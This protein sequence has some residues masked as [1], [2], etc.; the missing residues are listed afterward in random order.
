[1][2]L[3]NIT[4]QIFIIFSLDIIQSL[5]QRS[6]FRIDSIIFRLN[7]LQTNTRQSGNTFANH[8]NLFEPIILLSNSTKSINKL[9]LSSISLP[10]LHL[11]ISKP[12]ILLL[13]LVLKLLSKFLKLPLHILVLFLQADIVPPRLL[14]FM[15]QY[16]FILVDCV[17]LQP[18]LPHQLFY[19][20]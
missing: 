10:Q 17:H 1:M 7:I 14:K 20:I 9:S 3:I 6:F 16:L 2:Q 13:P 15:L 4:N 18:Q 8:G 5:P 19:F 11:L 12:T